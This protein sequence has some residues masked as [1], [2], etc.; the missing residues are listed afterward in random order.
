M[1]HWALAAEAGMPRIA[2]AGGEGHGVLRFAQDDSRWKWRSL[3]VLG[4]C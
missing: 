1:L 3:S 4:N 2:S